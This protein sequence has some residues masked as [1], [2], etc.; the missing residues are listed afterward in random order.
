M[1]EKPLKLALAGVV[2]LFVAQVAGKIEGKFFPVVS[3]V[4]I[5]RYEPAE[6]GYTRIWGTFSLDR[7]SCDFV[8]LAWSLK[9]ATRD[10]GADLVFEEGTRERDNGLQEFGPW[11][12]QLTQDQIRNRSSAT[13]IHSC[14]LRWWE[15]LTRFY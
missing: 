8:S 12:V 2:A 5:T 1:S 10:V 14:P 13:V 3:D 6:D 7:D 11:R 15:T 4:E 9:G